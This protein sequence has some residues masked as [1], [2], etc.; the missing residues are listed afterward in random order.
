MQHCR[1]FCHR[2]GEN[3]ILYIACIGPL[4]EAFTF[5]KSFPTPKD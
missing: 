1:F 2:L 5:K 4:K 3:A